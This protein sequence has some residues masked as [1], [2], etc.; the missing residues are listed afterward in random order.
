MLEDEKVDATPEPFEANSL[1]TVLTELNKPEPAPAEPDKPAEPAKPAEEAPKD[2][3]K[4]PADPAKP[5]EPKPDEK[6]AAVEPFK[7]GEEAKFKIS[8]KAVQTREEIEKLPYANDATFKAIM[9]EFEQLAQ[10]KT[11]MAEVLADG[12]YKIPDA[13]TLKAVVADA[14]SLYDIIN[15]KESPAALF[16]LAS[17][18]YGEENINQVI[19]GILLYAKEKGITEASYADLSKPENKRI[20]DLNKESRERRQNAER[21]A[22]TNRIAQNEKQVNQI[23]EKT[24]SHIEKLFTDLKIPKEDH[25]DYTTILLSQIEADP[26][27]REQVQQGK[28]GEIDRIV[29]EFNNRIVER[30]KRWEEQLTARKGAREDKLKGA[31]AP[32]GGAP[33]PKEAPK[34]KVN[35]NDDDER[36]DAVKKIIR[37]G[38]L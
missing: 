26:K 20:F 34:K 6:P 25:G 35:V 7:V 19:A 13:D 2:G 4:P 37:T 32:A 14:Y 27:I 17:K 38:E 29:T 28:Y 24:S 11:G 1:D 8:D 5:A 10:F 18:T 21:Q 33:P 23:I 30:Q 15:L 12:P 16:D 3:E 9:T 36:M 31:G 22:E